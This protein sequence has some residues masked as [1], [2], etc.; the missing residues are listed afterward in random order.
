MWARKIGAARPVAWIAAAAVVLLLAPTAM[1]SPTWVLK[2]AYRGA[3]GYHHS[4]V[5]SNSSQNGTTTGIKVTCS[6]T[7]GV[8]RSDVATGRVVASVY[9]NGTAVAP[10]KPTAN[11][12]KSCIDKIGLDV[13]FLGPN[14]TVN[15]SGGY[16]ISYRWSLSYAFSSNGLLTHDIELIGKVFDNTTGTY[17]SANNT[18]VLVSCT[19]TCYRTG[20][21]VNAVSTFHVHLKG[22]HSYK[23]FT[24]VHLGTI[25]SAAVS[26]FYNSGTHSHSCLALSTGVGNHISIYRFMHSSRLDSVRIS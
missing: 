13:G 6:A 17:L 21:G 20:I 5:I 1:G 26:C 24:V 12:S 14:F 10:S 25:S 15:A 23:F 9:A 8:A 22:T 7:V 4:S 2:P 18:T 16:A 3:V 19:S 11:G